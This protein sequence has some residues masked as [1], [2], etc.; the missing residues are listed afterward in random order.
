MNRKILLFLG[1]GLHALFFACKPKTPA[2]SAAAV[3]A[4]ETDFIC[5]MKVRANFTDTCHHKGNVYAFCSESCKMEFKAAPETFL[6]N[7][8]NH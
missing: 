8:E 5:G 7:A 6:S 3:F 4:N 1:L 2:T